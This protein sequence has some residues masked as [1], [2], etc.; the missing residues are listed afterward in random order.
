MSNKELYNILLDRTISYLI[1]EKEIMVNSLED[2][3]INDLSFKDLTPK[4]VEQIN[5]TRRSIAQ[6]YDLICDLEKLRK[7]V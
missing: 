7:E 4:E 5:R 6:C 3:V 1:E 2:M